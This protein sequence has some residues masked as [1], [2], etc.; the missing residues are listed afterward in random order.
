[1]TVR[2][3][4]L[5]TTVPIIDVGGSAGP[6]IG[7]MLQ[8]A[9]VL[10]AEPADRD[11]RL[12]RVALESSGRDVR[13]AAVR[14]LVARRGDAPVTARVLDALATEV[15]GELRL[16]ALRARGGVDGVAEMVRS[17]ALAPHWRV[18]ALRLLDERGGRAAAAPLVRLALNSRQTALV[19]AATELIRQDGPA[20]DPAVREA[21]RKSLDDAG[22]L[23]LLWKLQAL[24][25]CGTAD[26]FAVLAPWL[27]HS[28]AGVRDV[29]SSARKRLLERLGPRDQGAL[30][31]V[32]PGEE[33]GLSLADGAGEPGRLEVV[34][35]RE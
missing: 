9:Q 27:E 25:A 26:D 1:M 6:R 28:E 5:W 13:L 35:D 24:G 34:E 4:G 22:G 18:E 21:L 17:P 31:V 11:E 15:D 3:A 7:R 10:E 33:G 19:E 2:E 16:L 29:A 32:E 14:A 8:A 30:S 12:A 23:A 20:V